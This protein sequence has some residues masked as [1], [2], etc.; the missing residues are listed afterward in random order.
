[1]TARE[2]GFLLLTGYLGDPE[3]RPLSI[4]QF[5]KLTALART[6]EKPEQQREIT[7]EDLL[8]I[9][10]DRGT[11]LRVLNLLSQREQLRW[12]LEKGKR[13][14]CC[15]VTRISSAY[16]DRL[17]RALGLDAPGVL[18]TKGNAELLRLPAVALVGSRELCPDNHA[19]A[20]EVGKQAA[21]QGYVLVSGNARGADRTAQES[22]LACGG[23][24][25]SVIADVLADKP[26]HENVL[27]ISEEGFDLSFSTVR[28]LQR[29]RVIHSFSDKTFVAQTAMGKGGT[30]SGT[31]H[32]LRCGLSTVLCYDDGS[33]ASRELQNRGAT[34]VTG[35]GLQD[36]SALKTDIV[37]F[38]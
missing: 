8:A 3:R 20:A 34:L 37:S 22:C 15:P 14:G 12:Y 32:N 6:M 9:G 36:I 11:A 19:F 2:Q 18:W 10:C 4:A 21:L 25:I 27:Y 13:S 35:A 1:M 30:W 28:A 24:V 31:C 5:R 38:C 26:Q 7:V 29:N 16:P 33:A 23:K 17:R